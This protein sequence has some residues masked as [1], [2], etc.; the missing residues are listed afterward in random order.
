MEVEGAEEMRGSGDLLGSEVRVAVPPVRYAETVQRRR[1]GRVQ[2]VLTDVR[3]E[4]DTVESEQE[5]QLD[6]ALVEVE[7]A[8]HCYRRPR[9]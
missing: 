7:H 5:V 2:E 3:G 9:P 4:R 8:P 1:V 6:P